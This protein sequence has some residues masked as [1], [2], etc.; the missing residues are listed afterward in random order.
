MEL[1]KLRYFEVLA[2]ELHFGRAARRLHITQPPLSMA[3]QSLEDELGVKLFT[4][5]P[6]HV[7]LTHAGTVFLEQARTLLARAQDA[8]EL[9]RAADRGEVGRLRI[10]F[11]SGTIY[12]LLP[13]L[14]RD[15]AARFPAVKQK[16]VSD[17]GRCDQSRVDGV[18]TLL[19]RVVDLLDASFL[20]GGDPFHLSLAPKVRLEPS[21]TDRAP[22]AKH[23][24][25]WLPQ[26]SD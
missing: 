17:A 18:E 4:R 9:V 20:R 14:L 2:D 13:P 26:A 19:G 21:E 16:E 8:I 15:F 3:I 25:N 6:R 11:M 10:G 7:T 24:T 22:S 23:P 5:A 12:T 1:R